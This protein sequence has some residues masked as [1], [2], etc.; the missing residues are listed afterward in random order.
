[1]LDYA[2]LALK[3]EAQKRE[4]ALQNSGETDEHDKD[5]QQICQTSVTHKPVN[6]PEQDR[7]D[8]DGNEDVDQDKNHDN[9][10]G[11]RVAERKSDRALSCAL[12]RRPV[13]EQFVS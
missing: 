10:I 12:I 8:D 2:R 3:A 6:N 5:L 4:Q 9:P 13:V 7:A 1:M 11:Q